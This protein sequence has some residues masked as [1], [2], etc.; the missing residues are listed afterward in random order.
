[1]PGLTGGSAGQPPF[2]EGQVVTVFRSRR[3]DGADA[4]YRALVAD[5]LAAAVSAAGFVDFKTFSAE[6]GEHVSVVTFATADAHRA[7][8]DDPRHRRAQRRGQDAFYLEYSVQ[9]GT[10]SHVSRWAREPD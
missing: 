4:D 6:D 7:W 10:C 5:M 2:A 8:R 3:V 1:M 9:V